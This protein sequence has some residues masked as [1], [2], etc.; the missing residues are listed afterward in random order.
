MGKDEL[1]GVVILHENLV[2]FTYKHS[3]TFVIP[4]SGFM[5]G[6]PEHTVEFN[7]YTNF[8]FHITIALLESL[9][10]IVKL[11]QERIVSS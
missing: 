3:H 9:L 1:R 5:L 10:S 11:L 2:R 6:I 7:L 4:N 8:V